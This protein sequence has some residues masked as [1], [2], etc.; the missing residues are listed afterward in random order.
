ML[1]MPKSASEVDDDDVHYFLMESGWGRALHMVA[2]VNL[3]LKKMM[4]VM[5]HFPFQLI[6]GK[7]GASLD[8]VSPKRFVDFDWT[9]VV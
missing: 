1:N 7:S 5:G 9:A 6:S 3:I 2:F 4:M 8:L